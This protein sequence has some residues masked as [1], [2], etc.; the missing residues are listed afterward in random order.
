LSNFNQCCFSAAEDR[1]SFVN[2]PSL[3]DF[4]ISLE[5]GRA[6]QEKEPARGGSAVAPA[7]SIAFAD[8][9]RS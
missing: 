2:I 7:I 4:Q 9:L 6:A 3:A 5:H 1:A 8:T